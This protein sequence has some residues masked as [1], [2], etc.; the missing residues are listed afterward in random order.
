MP[1]IF[2]L[3][4]SFVNKIEYYLDRALHIVL[5]LRFP[6]SEATLGTCLMDGCTQQDTVLPMS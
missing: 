3:N 1:V 2:Y 5:D 6:L 4:L